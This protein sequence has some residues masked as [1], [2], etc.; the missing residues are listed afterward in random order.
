M[1]TELDILQSTEA[2]KFMKKF[3]IQHFAEGSDPEPPKPPTDPEPEP[4][5]PEP[6]PEPTGK[7]FSQEQFEKELKRR[8]ATE[9]K[10]LEKE[11]EEAKKL[12]KM[13]EQERLEHERDEMKK[14]LEELKKKDAFYGMSRE[15]TKMLA[16][17]NIPV[18]DEVLNFVVKEDAEN[19]QSAVKSFID[20][21]NDLAGKLVKE[22]LSGKPPERKGSTSEGYNPYDS[23]TLNLTAQ[24]ELELSDPEKAKRLEAAA[25]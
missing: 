25:K 12:E 20:L 8:L 18:S 19:T 2:P 6:N 24:A 21:V 10:K 16:E 22:R 14:E 4:S 13:N 11:V 7:T 23:K 15:A 1:K 17:A 9:K 5:T 3:Y